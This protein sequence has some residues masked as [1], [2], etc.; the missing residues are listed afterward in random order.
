MEQTIRTDAF[1]RQLYDWANTMAENRGYATTRSAPFPADGSVE[2]ET[3]CLSGYQFWRAVETWKAAMRA[4]IERTKEQ[5][6]KVGIV[7][8]RIPEIRLEKFEDAHP[9][10]VD[11]M[12]QELKDQLR[13]VITSRQIITNNPAVR[14]YMEGE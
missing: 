1:G 10:L 6:R 8:R 13:W 9:E 4:R 2:V 11:S 3:W 12:D 5:G 7:W 14:G